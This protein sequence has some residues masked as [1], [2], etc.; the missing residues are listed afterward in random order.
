MVYISNYEDARLWELLRRHCA[1]CN[2]P[3][4]KKALRKF[5]D[6]K[7]KDRLTKSIREQKRCYF[8]NWFDMYKEYMII[9]GNMTDNEV[10]EW[11]KDE[12]YIPIVHS[13]YDCTGRWFTSSYH[14]KRCIAGIAIVHCVCCDV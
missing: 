8:G 11:I 4:V 1:E 14:W 6:R 9:D 5:Y 2:T 12:L 10:E 7:C 13:M 3:D